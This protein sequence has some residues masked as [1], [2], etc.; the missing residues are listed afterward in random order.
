ML[1]GYCLD[2]HQT[3]C[4]GEAAETLPY[5]R[6]WPTANLNI[7]SAMRQINSFVPVIEMLHMNVALHWYVYCVTAQH[8]YTQAKMEFFSQDGNIR[9]SKDRRSHVTC[10]SAT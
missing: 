1:G 7:S 6:I 5:S 4:K 2:L 3:S 9:P 10:I 8:L